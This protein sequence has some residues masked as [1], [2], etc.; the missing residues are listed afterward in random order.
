[1]KTK[2]INLLFV[3][4]ILTLSCNNSSQENTNVENSEQQNEEQTP[5][6]D[7]ELIQEI[8]NNNETDFINIFTD[9]ENLPTSADFKKFS[10][11]IEQ[12]K[13]FWQFS[14][15]IKGQI[16]TDASDYDTYY[17]PIG[18]YKFNKTDYLLFVAEQQEDT[19]IIST[20]VWYKLVDGDKRQRFSR[21]MS[22]LKQF[23]N[24]KSTDFQFV[25]NNI[26]TVIVYKDTEKKQPITFEY[27]QGRFYNLNNL[28]KITDKTKVLNYS[29]IEFCSL[30]PKI[31]ND[32]KSE[33]QINLLKNKSK[34]DEFSIF[35]HKKT[36]LG[37]A[38]VSEPIS[39]EARYYPL[40]YRQINDSLHLLILLNKAPDFKER[41]L[42]LVL[43]KDFENIIESRYISSNQYYNPKIEFN[44]NVL[45]FSVNNA[46][47]NYNAKLLLSENGF[48]IEK[49]S[50]DKYF[51]KQLKFPYTSDNKLLNLKSKQQIPFVDILGINDFYVDSDV[52]FIGKL[53]TNR[54]YILLFY[55]GY[56]ITS[57]FH[58]FSADAFAY[59]LDKSNLKITDKIGAY[60]YFSDAGEESSSILYS[61]KFYKQD[62]T[63]EKAFNKKPMDSEITKYL[64]NYGF[65]ENDVV[66][67][68]QYQSSFKYE[69]S[70]LELIPEI[71]FPF[72]YKPIENEKAKSE[73]TDLNKYFSNVIDS[74]KFINENAENYLPIYL[75]KGKIKLSDTT[76]LIV[77]QT[78]IK[79]TRKNEYADLRP[80]LEAAIYNIKSQ[81]FIAIKEIPFEE[82]I[83]Q[84]TIN[85]AFNLNK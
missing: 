74:L 75:V 73:L 67:K 40:G 65:F 22:I 17:Q 72:E 4:L 48:L 36:T 83:N 45:S 69:K 6:E 84:N 52:D 71:Q 16:F 58:A 77:W 43:L 55:Q 61:D 76:S 20:L 59:L 79:E 31:D 14:S 66:T 32:W 29:F 3:F 54:F 37:A 26:E 70:F 78:W 1:M 12:K 2:I 19:T 82:K 33:K 21:G 8:V 51:K 18:K 56:E 80:I 46:D 41:E 35:V 34:N 68:R 64:T 9:F 28:V 49:N 10:Y 38:Y 63:E 85:Q 42:K 50:F 57:G 30:F 25:N 24:N 13:D 47:K 39:F 7:Q 44:N 27:Y 62:I 53:E 23:P 5:V 81:N 60:G 11:N 15:F